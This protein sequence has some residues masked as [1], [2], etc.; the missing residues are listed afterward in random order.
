[1]KLQIR[2]VS[3]L[4]AITFCALVLTVPLTAQKNPNHSH[5]QYRLAQIGTFGGPTSDYVVGP[6]FAYENYFNSQGATV[7]DASTSTS[8]PFS[9]NCFYD[10]FVDR[11]MTF[12]DGI[13]RDLG[14]I[15]IGSSSAAYGINDWGL[16][17]GISENGVVDPGTGYP[18]YHAVIWRH[19]ELLDLGTLGGTVSQAFAV[20][21]QNQVVGV[22]T[23]A[24]PD[25]YSSGL[26]P[27]TTVNCWP[28]TT[29]QRAILWDHGTLRDLGTLGGDDAVAYFVN[30]LG[31][32]AGVSIRTRL[33][34]ERPGFP[35]RIR[36]C[37]IAVEWWIS[38]AW[39]VP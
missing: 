38:E 33:P 21:N 17:V 4:G 15:S 14:A 10:C 5:P 25:P 31:Q 26:G 34:T 12:Q 29:Q 11:A 36:S 18:E 22:A 9:P 2:L 24:T 6:G 8:D 28:V 20:N 35:R 30:E 19:G 3:L 1:M 37:G 13:L 16:I 39:G 32:I 23:N 27:C 7:G